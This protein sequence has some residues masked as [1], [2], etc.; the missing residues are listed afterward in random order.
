MKGQTVSRVYVDDLLVMEI[1]KKRVEEASN[2]SAKLYINDLVVV[3]RF[4]G[5]R[6]SHSIHD[7]YELDQESII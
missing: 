6:S 4:L 5:K 7:G 2:L 3:K 1:W